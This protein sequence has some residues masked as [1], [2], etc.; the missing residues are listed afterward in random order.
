[1]GDDPEL[2]CDEVLVEALVV[3]LLGAESALAR[4]LLA[5]VPEVVKLCNI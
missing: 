3:A 2:P 1:L 5:V 4:A